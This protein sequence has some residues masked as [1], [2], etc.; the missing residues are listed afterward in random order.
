[1]L[2]YRLRRTAPRFNSAAS[3]NQRPNSPE[4]Q[5]YSSS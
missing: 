1:M 3:T 2:L 5:R 4:N